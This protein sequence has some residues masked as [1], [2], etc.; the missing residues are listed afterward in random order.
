MDNQGIVKNNENTEVLNIY[1]NTA[2]SSDLL[3][4]ADLKSEYNSVEAFHQYLRSLN[5]KSVY[6]ILESSV[7][8]IEGFASLIDIDNIG[9]MTNFLSKDLI[10]VTKSPLGDAEVCENTVTNYY[11]PKDSDSYYEWFVENGT[12]EAQSKNTLTVKWDKGRGTG[13]IKAIKTNL[14][15]A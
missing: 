8:S 12:I 1:I 10:F 5:I 2:K 11:Y 14:K 3:Q 4:T 7:A 13:N 6:K 15:L 9:M